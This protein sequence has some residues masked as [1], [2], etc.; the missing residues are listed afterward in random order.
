MQGRVDT[1]G[2]DI[3]KSVHA[4]VGVRMWVEG[5]PLRCWITGTWLYSSESGFVIA[6]VYL[7]VA[8]LAPCQLLPPCAVEG[9]MMCLVPFSFFWFKVPL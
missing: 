4:W 8:H 9:D 1:P 6:S 5:G 2:F 3:A 7:T